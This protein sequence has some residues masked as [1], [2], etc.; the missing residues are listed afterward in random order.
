MSKLILLTAVSLLS[1]VAYYTLSNTNEISNKTTLSSTISKTTEKKIE[2]AYSST[3]TEE[4]DSYT[5]SDINP[6]LDEALQKVHTNNRDSLALSD[7]YTLIELFNSKSEELSKEY[8][9]IENLYQH[10]KNEKEKIFLITFLG[11]VDTKEAVESILKLI[12]SDTDASLLLQHNIH[13]ALENLVFNDEYTTL[14]KQLVPY[15]E[16]YLS[17]QD[18]STYK[19]EVAKNLIALKESSSMPLILKTIENGSEI[20][21]KQLLFALKKPLNQESTQII[22]DTY[23]NPNTNSSIKKELLDTLAYQDDDASLIELLEY[24]TNADESEAEHIEELFEIAN[25]N[26]Y[27]IE[28]ILADALFGDEDTFNS[29]LIKEAILK[30]IKF[31]S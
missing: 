1:V 8:Q 22:L 20:E 12:D 10:S 9:K 3:K 24:A 25:E 28:K 21:Q 16:E 6:L 14:N 19:V 23:K 4:D 29:P 30:A 7:V 13:N 17:T 26:N 31:E 2:V 15:F 11:N 5:Y 18:E 27:N